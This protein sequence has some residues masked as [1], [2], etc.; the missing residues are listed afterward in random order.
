M[1]K[2]DRTI[3]RTFFSFE[4]GFLY[5]VHVSFTEWNRIVVVGQGQRSLNGIFGSRKSIACAALPGLVVPTLRD[6][7]EEFKKGNKVVKEDPNMDFLVSRAYDKEGTHWTELRE[8]SGEVL[9]EDAVN[10]HLLPDYLPG[11]SPDYL[12]EVSELSE[13]AE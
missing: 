10:S 4:D 3:L 11:Y 8:P 2:T 9:A 12:P 5:W 1:K 7:V 13:E 6:V